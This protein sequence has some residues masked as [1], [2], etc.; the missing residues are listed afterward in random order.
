MNNKVRFF[1]YLLCDKQIVIFR[2][3]LTQYNWAS[4]FPKFLETNRA[5]T[6]TQ[7]F[8]KWKTRSHACCQSHTPFSCKY[9]IY[10]PGCGHRVLQKILQTINYISLLVETLNTK[11]K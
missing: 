1:H 4:L 9:S 6:A 3:E 11:I 2:I 8:N 7:E 10:T 5:E